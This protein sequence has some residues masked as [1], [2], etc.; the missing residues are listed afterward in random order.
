MSL[1]TWMSQEGY[2]PL[3][4]EVV[5]EQVSGSFWQPAFFGPTTSGN[6][7]KSF[8]EPQAEERNCQQVVGHFSLY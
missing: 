6:E 3:L 7:D 5:L 1:R 4:F 2:R 8:R